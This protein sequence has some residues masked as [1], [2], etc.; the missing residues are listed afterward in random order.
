MS[1]VNHNL[2]LSDL[3]ANLLVK[4]REHARYIESGTAPCSWC[5]CYKR[6]HLHDGRCS[7]SAVSQ[8]FLYEGHVTVKAIEKAIRLV[9]ELMGL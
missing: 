4:Q 7:S 6:N 3:Y 1:V 2:S 5:N 8:S 9:E